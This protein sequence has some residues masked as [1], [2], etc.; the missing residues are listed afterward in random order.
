MPVPERAVALADEDLVEGGQDERQQHERRRHQVGELQAGQDE[1]REAVE[2]A[3]DEGR[4]RPGDPAPDDDER[5]EGRE[6][7]RDR[8]GHVERRHRAPDPRHRHEREAQSGDRRLRQQVD[9]GRMEQRARE[10]RVLPVGQRGGR[11]LEE[12]QEQRGV[13]AAAQGVCR[14]PLSPGV[15]PQEE[16]ER[17]I[18]HA[19]GYEGHPWSPPS[20]LARRVLSQLRAC[21]PWRSCGAAAP[22]RP[23][24][25][26]PP[27]G[28]P[29]RR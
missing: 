21:L 8:R 15:H 4:R 9:A 13:A 28:T 11:P 17:E 14:R 7:G 25:S 3:A 24:R 12:P 27:R 20:R 1:G 26:T 16:P 5:G 23:V 6:R 18:Q 19:P 2:Q 22:G 10:E 29:P